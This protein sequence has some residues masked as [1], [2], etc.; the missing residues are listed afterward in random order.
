MWI[1]VYCNE[2][3]LKGDIVSYN[4]ETSL[5]E[6]ASSMSTPVGVAK[7]DA[8]TRID[9]NNNERWCCK[10]VVSGDCYARASRDIPDQGGELKIENG[11]AYVDN[12]SDS[13]G[14][15]YPNFIDKPQRIANDQIMIFLR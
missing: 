4:E 12:S 11:G 15:I 13:C 9:L 8:V 5:W 1:K 7:E 6:K 14:I 10:M 3:V 2:N